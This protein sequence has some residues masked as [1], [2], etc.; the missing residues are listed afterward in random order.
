MVLAPQII[1]LLS[2]YGYEGAI[3]PMRIIMPAVLS[4]AIA[5]VLAIQVL[6][7]MKKDIVLLRAS[8]IGAFV[9]LVLNLIIVVRFESIG[10]AVVLVVSETVVTMFYLIYAIR[11]N[12]IHFPLRY[13]F[14]SVI[15]ALPSVMICI[16]CKNLINNNI[17]TIIVALFAGGGCWIM[18]LY[19]GRLYKEL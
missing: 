17:M 16:L 10:S 15:C 2:G 11:H 14:Q 5:Q 19:L 18:L 9:A 12:L 6:I 3:L 13:F 8:V 7:P 4:V 1:Y